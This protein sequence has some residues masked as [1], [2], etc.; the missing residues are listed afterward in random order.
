MNERFQ[1]QQSARLA[2]DKMRREVHCAS[3]VTPIGASSSITVTLPSQCPTSGGSQANIVYDLSSS[4]R[5]DTASA[6][7][8]SPSR[9]GSRATPSSTYTAPQ[10][11]KLATLRVDLPVDPSAAKKHV[12]RLQTDIV[13]RN[14]TRL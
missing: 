6:G 12:W 2:V 14:T 7:R 1:A 13:L 10:T 9:T 11:G 3:S 5:T 8:A 4:R